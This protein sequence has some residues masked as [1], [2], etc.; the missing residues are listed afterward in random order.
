[1]EFQL[2]YYPNGSEKA[3]A[4]VRAEADE[5]RIREFYEKVTSLV[6]DMGNIAADARKYTD[7]LTSSSE[8][9]DRSAP[10]KVLYGFCENGKTLKPDALESA[11][12]HLFFNE[13][14]AIAAVLYG[15]SLL[16]DSGDEKNGSEDNLKNTLE[17]IRFEQ[18]AD[19][20]IVIEDLHLTVDY[21]GDTYTNIQEVSI[22]GGS[23]GISGGR[24]VGKKNGGQPNTYYLLAKTTKCGGPEYRGYTIVQSPSFGMVEA[25]P[26][27]RYAGN[28]LNFKESHEPASFNVIGPA[29]PCI[30]ED[31][32]VLEK[33]EGGTI[34]SV[35]N[36][37]KIDPDWVNTV[38]LFFERDGEDFTFSI[39]KNGKLYKKISRT[40]D[41]VTFYGTRF[42]FAADAD[43]DKLVDIVFRKTNGRYLNEERTIVD[44]AGMTNFVNSS[45]EMPSIP[46]GD[47]VN[48]AD[49][50]DFYD[51]CVEAFYK[52]FE[53]SEKYF[54]TQYQW[55][56]PDEARVV[57]WSEKT[58]KN[59][60][61]D[62]P[63]ACQL[64]ISR[65]DKGEYVF[66][67]EDAVVTAHVSAA[68]ADMNFKEYFFPSFPD[69][70]VDSVAF[71]ED[72][73]TVALR[74]AHGQMYLKITDAKTGQVY[75]ERFA[76]LRMEPDFDSTGIPMNLYLGADWVRVKGNLDLYR[77]I[78]DAVMKFGVERCEVLLDGY[79]EN[80]REKIA[81]L[82]YGEE[83]MVPDETVISMVEQLEKEYE[84]T[85]RIPNIAIVGQAGTGKTTLA[86]NLGKIFGKEVL[87]LTPSDL[88]GAYIGH[89]KYEVV[90][91]LAEAAIN[92]Q[93]FYV[94]EAYQLMDD[95]FG[96]EA[97]TVL[98]PLMSGDRT[99][100]DASVHQRPVIEVDFEKGCYKKDSVT[101]T[102][103]PG[104]VPIWISGY[105]NE[106]RMMINQNQGLYRRLK[107]VIIKPPTTSDLLKKFTEEL[108]KIARG[109]GKA[110]RN[111]LRLKKYFNENGCEA[112]KKFFSWGAQPQNSKYFAN[113]AGVGNF[114]ANCL[115]SIDFGRDLGSQIEEIISSSKL[116]I[117][118]QLAA[119]RNGS[120]NGNHASSGSLSAVFDAKD[121]IQVITDIDTRFSDLVGCPSQVAYMQ[122]IIEMLINKSVYED[123]NLA[124][125]K[126]AL[127]EGL[128]GVGK[129]FIARAMAGELEQRFQ[130][131][132][133]DKRFGFMAFSASELGKKPANYIASIFNTAEE[134]DA[135]VL[136]IDEVDAIARHRNDNPSYDNYLE[137]IKQ[138]DG[139]EKRSNVFILAATNA[140]ENLDPAFVRSGRIDKRLE[141][142]LPDK[143]SRKELAGRAIRKRMKTLVNFI[144]EGKEEDINAIVERIAG[145]TSGNTAGD[146]DNMINTAFI[147]Y[148]QF[149]RYGAH[150]NESGSVIDRDF[151]ESYPF[152]TR[153]QKSKRLEISV[154]DGNGIKDRALRE[155]CLFIDEEIERKQ[156]GVPNYK[157]REAEFN[158]DRNGHNCSSV[159]IHEVGHAVVSLMVSEEPFDIITTLPRGDALGYV[160]H[161]ELKL[162]TKSDYERRIRV[163]MGGRIAEEMIYGKD[164]VST[165]AT[166]DMQQATEYARAM[167]ERWGFSDK[168]GFM[169]LSV[170]VGRY[171]GGDRRYTCSEE[172]RAD[173]DIAVNE[174]LQKLYRETLGMLSGREELIKNLAEHVFEK[175]TM[176]GDEFKRLY[177]A[178]LKKS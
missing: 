5:S 138:M 43:K 120:S 38:H 172:F 136:F 7:T 174:L 157:E 31:G 103:A 149:I 145:K 116:D 54:T 121:S 98:L 163:C 77:K 63:P 29:S 100:I 51:K 112:V 173:S 40:D 60:G 123:Y 158:T 131:E 153:D 151:F 79:S 18:G 11:E 101:E 167:T 71:S 91:K 105:E 168:F 78:K 135:C 19:V 150:E 35:E 65:G 170:P 6:E 26:A 2:S 162:V 90:Q 132:A 34:R 84:R 69:F 140:P 64:V 102:F 73:G 85:K 74:P 106:V 8:D 113:N 57:E 118:R 175:E 68:R 82:L 55:L 48:A 86:K 22:L 56:S 96:A 33:Y 27:Y 143:D 75:E 94:D 24:F 134:Y 32:N 72:G 164:N 87:P 148:H 37:E 93:I 108:E 166:S 122:S 49:Y 130:K 156:T 39:L 58:R 152:I 66:A 52:A 119:V 62:T 59:L 47:K 42:S 137:L 160:S 83:G 44:A 10:A 154:K 104:V 1:M 141:F 169:A 81:G 4:A 3:T 128:P 144:P 147:M 126:G 28:R 115:D 70:A 13:E 46:E 30:D 41:A 36:A 61:T 124:V 165:G 50:S 92:N 177:D 14:D 20:G 16:H 67:F 89:T 111:A 176:S 12:K 76:L 88:R 23:L 155:L 21:K 127:M 25:E 95:R 107:K 45:I 9:Y 17:P 99:K 15:C 80:R 110:A 97:V 117:K 109:S 53:N 171:L 114:L 161:P 142:I 159:A 139:I 125:P 178:E 133:P 129:T 146:I